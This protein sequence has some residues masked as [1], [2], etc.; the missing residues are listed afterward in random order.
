LIGK[1]KAKDIPTKEDTKDVMEAISAQL[2]AAI[3]RKEEAKTTEEKL[4]ATAAL[5]A[6]KLTQKQVQI[7]LLNNKSI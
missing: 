3:K 7:N 5:D 1:G 2:K 4:A 6:V